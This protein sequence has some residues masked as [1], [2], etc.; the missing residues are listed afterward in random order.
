VAAETKIDP[1]HQFMIDPIYGQLGP[2]NPFAFTNSSLWMLLLLVLITGFMLM[3]MR[4]E[5]IPGRWQVAAEGVVGFMNSMVVSSIGPQG[6]TYLPWIFTAFI[7]ILFANIVGAMPFAVVPGAHPFTVTSQ[8]TVTGA[9]SIIS[10]AI[11]L[12]VGFWKHG[13]HFFSLFVPKD[14]PFLLKLLITPVEVISFAV[15]PF[16]LGLRPFIAMFAGHILLD[17]F[18]NFVVQGINSQTAVGYGVSG[19]AFLFVIFVNALELLVGAI[20]AYVFALLTSLY[21]GD[22]VNLH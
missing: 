22:A 14:T 3:G 6:R 10:F 4:R 5:L 7:F 8:F 13:L 16:S 1:M 21:I 15:R 17:V 12:G 11:V 20:Q 2:H 9:M 19:L 18:G